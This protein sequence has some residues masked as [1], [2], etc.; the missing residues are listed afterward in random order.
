MRKAMSQGD[1]PA[2]RMSRIADGYADLGD[3]HSAIAIFDATIKGTE[4]TQPSWI[5]VSLAKANMMQRNGMDGISVIEDHIVKAKG[6]QRP[7]QV[8]A[9]IAAYVVNLQLAGRGNEAPAWLD[10]MRDVVYAARDDI[11]VWQHYPE[12]LAACRALGRKDL[13]V[14]I[15]DIG[16]SSRADRQAMRPLWAEMGLD[17]QM[18]VK[19]LWKDA[20]K[21]SPPHEKHRGPSRNSH[22]H[23]PRHA[24][25]GHAPPH[26]R[27]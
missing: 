6:K 18:L 27:R 8:A 4:G 24:H 20:N 12:Y 10:Q 3:V 7:D 9:S 17:R 26:R 15:L 21:N 16:T 19:R 25:H 22:H 11:R 1:R 14:N 5:D 23:N 2:I 13:A